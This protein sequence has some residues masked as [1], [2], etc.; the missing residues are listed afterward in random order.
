M[1]DRKR[2]REGLRRRDFLKGGLAAGVALAAPV[3]FSR[4]ASAQQTRV[5][6]VVQ[7][8][9]FVPDYDRWFETF[10]R[11][12]GEKN[13]CKVEVDYVDT[14]D[15][16]T[17]IAADISRRGGHD[18]FHLNGTG[19]WLYDGVSVDVTGVAR[20]YAGII[21]TLIVDTADAARA[22]DVRR[23]GVR[24]IVAPT[25]M[26]DDAASR[27]LAEAALAAASVEP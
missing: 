17:A 7:W 1:S 19:A 13:K 9:H 2:S 16:P 26:R 15:L 25:I 18:V 23:E 20:V 12:F 24:C 10:A 27:S 22:D 14:A 6:K 21:D 11:E 5:L 4:S 8:K 3:V